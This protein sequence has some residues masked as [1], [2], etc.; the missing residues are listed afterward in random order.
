MYRHVPYSS[1]GNIS[2]KRA[3][4]LNVK[5]GITEKMNCM[6]GMLRC[7]FLAMSYFKPHQVNYKCEN[8][9]R[10][11]HFKNLRNLIPRFHISIYIKIAFYR[12][13]SIYP[14]PLE[15]VGSNL[16]PDIYVLLEF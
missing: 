11:V 1:Y 7:A 16:P 4:I 10:S 3:L 9:H 14:V 5:I 15:S 8:A 6:L 2:S 13:A 12:A